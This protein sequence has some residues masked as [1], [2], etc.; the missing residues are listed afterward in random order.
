MSN[1]QTV[2]PTFFDLYGRG[3][4]AADQIEDFVGQW[5]GSGI[6]EKRSL[7]AFLGLT[8][9]EYGVL[10]MDPDALPQVLTARRTGRPLHAVMAD[11]LTVLRRAARPEDRAVVMAL[12]HWLRERSGA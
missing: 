5:H 8:D 4:V 11:H 6:D 1:V 9:E 7:A 3:E 12:G 2:S 10:L